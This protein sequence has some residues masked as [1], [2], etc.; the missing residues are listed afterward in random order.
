MLFDDTGDLVRILV[1][2]VVAYIALIAILRV[3]GKRTLT[4]MNAFDLVVTVAMG[5]TLATVLLSSEVSL[6]EGILALFLLIG[7]QYSIA[8][9]TVRWRPSEKL[10]KSEP[11]MLLFQGEYMKQT[12]KHERV[13][14]AEI[15]EVL[16]ASG[17]SALD[18]ALAVVLES[19][20]TFSVIP[21]SAGASPAGVLRNVSR[22]EQNP[23]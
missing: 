9:V 23:T 11:T 16:R 6:S 19:N 17:L 2:G 3:S 21:F 8:W 20:G 15:L 12:M 4:Q 22:R 18:Q 14:E 13:S 5:S 10:F 1:V 7:M